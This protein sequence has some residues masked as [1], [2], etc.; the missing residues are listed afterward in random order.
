MPGLRQSL[1][2][3]G[4]GPGC[5]EV[6]LEDLTGRDV[7]AVNQAVNWV[8]RVDVLA[9]MDPIDLIQPTIQRRD[10]AEVWCHIQQVKYAQD[11]FPWARICEGAG[12]LASK[13]L[14]KWVRR[15]PGVAKVD[16]PGLDHILNR[17]FQRYGFQIP[18]MAM[19]LVTA[20]VRGYRDVVVY[21]APMTGTGSAARPAQGY[22]DEADE[23]FADRWRREREL[24]SWAV[25]YLRVWHRCRVRR[26]LPQALVACAT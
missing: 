13:R 5:R 16:L 14:G 1:A 25:R 3:I 21:G 19:A 11:A 18:T 15:E 6:T 4:T 22:L 9:F 20:G 23:A 10:F 24:F 26:V 17:Q 12:E 2:I 8:P 7:V